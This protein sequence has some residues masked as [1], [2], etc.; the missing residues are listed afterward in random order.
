MTEDGAIGLRLYYKQGKEKVELVP[1]ERTDS[2]LVIE[3]GEYVC[4][5]QCP[6]K[7]AA[8]L[9]AYHSTS[10]PCF[11]LVFRRD[12]L[13]QQ[14]EQ[15][16]LKEGL[17]PHH[18]RT[19]SGGRRP[20]TGQLTCHQAKSHNTPKKAVQSLIHNINP[21]LRRRLEHIFSTTK[22]EI[23]GVDCG[24]SSFRPSISRIDQFNKR[25]LANT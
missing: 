2:H 17:V 1:S 13:R 4:Q 9:Y 19:S 5:H 23:D 3:E 24:D 10:T 8:G 21:I 15:H 11:L 14:S 16:A 12:R 22:Q 18:S 6:C 7:S 20:T 25:K